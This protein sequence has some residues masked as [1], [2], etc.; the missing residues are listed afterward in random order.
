MGV[1]VLVVI[2][3]EGTFVIVVKVIRVSVVEKVDSVYW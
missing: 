2:R 1:T 3:G